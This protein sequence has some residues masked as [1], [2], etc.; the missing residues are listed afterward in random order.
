MGWESA[1]LVSFHNNSLVCQYTI[2]ERVGSP[3]TLSLS[4]EIKLTVR[5]SL[6]L[7]LVTMEKP[8]VSMAT[9]VLCTFS[10]T[11]LI[12]PTK[13]ITDNNSRHE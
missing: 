4:R 2:Y 12:K 5:D 7:P 3:V 13:K 10:S 11:Y 9:P 1:I 6:F 8:C